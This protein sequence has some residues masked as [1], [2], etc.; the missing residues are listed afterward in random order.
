MRSNT[1]MTAIGLVLAL[2]AMTAAWPAHAA[3]NDIEQPGGNGAAG[4]AGVD[5]GPGN[6]ACIGE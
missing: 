3:V 2:T 6:D 5:G 1:P 4:T